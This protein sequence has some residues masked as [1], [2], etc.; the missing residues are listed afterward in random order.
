MDLIYRL[1]EATAAQVQAA[2]EDQPNYSAVRALLGVLVDKG[3]VKVAKVEGARH[4]VYSAKEPLKKASKGALM[5]LLATFF[6]DSPTAL[7]A[8]L[9][10]P[11]ERK[12]KPADLDHI[13]SLI[14]SHRQSIN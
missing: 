4:Y 11:T 14:D 7:V 13:Q 9:L 1:G 12:L 2:M 10:D 6:D 8:N 5:R 3:H